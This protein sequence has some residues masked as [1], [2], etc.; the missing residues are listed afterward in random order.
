MA[1]RRLVTGVAT[2]AALGCSDSASDGPTTLPFFETPNSE[3]GGGE[4]GDTE[5]SQVEPG[6]NAPNGEDVQGEPNAPNLTP[7]SEAQNP[8]NT[9]IAGTEPESNGAQLGEASEGESQT[10]EETTGEEPAPPEDQTT[11]EPVVEPQ[12][13]PEPEPEFPRPELNCD[14]P[15]PQLTNPVHETCEANTGESVNGQSVWFWYNESGPGGCM[16]TYDSLAGAFTVT[17]NNPVDILGRIGPWFDETTTHQEEGEMVADLAFTKQGSGGSYSFIGIYGWTLNPMI[18]YYIVE[19][20]FPGAFSPPFGT[21]SRGAINVDGAQYDVH[22][23]ERFNQPAIT[24]QNENFTQVFSVRRNKRQCGRV[25][26][27]EHFRQWE[28]M[29]INL[30]FMKEAKIVVEAG[31]GSGSVTFHHAN[32]QVT[33]PEDAE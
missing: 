27:S 2:I 10:P 9:S 4:P 31:G 5:G 13:E 32:V 14:A 7:S 29:G 26:I 8:D 15:P 24:G 18:E 11:E 28:S 20:D 25:S 23:G 21:N 6:V 19:D 16:N 1:L 22:T 17:W 33:P 3:A 30:G 12:P